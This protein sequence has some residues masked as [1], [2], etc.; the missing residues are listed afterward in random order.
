MVAIDDTAVE[1]RGLSYRAVVTQVGEGL[2]TYDFAMFSPGLT[3][4]AVPADE[5]SP[6]ESG[7]LVF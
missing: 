5:D 7:S 6:P 1:R 3:V 4:V 2:P